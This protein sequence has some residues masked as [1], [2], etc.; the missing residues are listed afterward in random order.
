MLLKKQTVTLPSLFSL[1]SEEID[2]VIN[3][4][5]ESLISSYAA[6]NIFALTEKDKQKIIENLPAS[7]HGLKTR[8]EQ[9]TFKKSEQ[10]VGGSIPV[11]QGFQ[12]PV[13]IHAARLGK[14]A[15]KDP[16]IMAL[17]WNKFKNQNKIALFL[18]V[19]RSSVNRRCKA[20]QIADNSQGVA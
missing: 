3:G 7:F 15:L 12:D 2:S 20:F 18:G 4:F 8:V 5:S 11:D 1:S 6:K 9:V 13:L 19:N 16:E 10:V 14:Q 17:L